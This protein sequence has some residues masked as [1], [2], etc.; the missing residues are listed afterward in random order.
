MYNMTFA[1]VSAKTKYNLE[2]TMDDFI[3]EI[4]KDR[5]E[6]VSLKDIHMNFLLGLNEDFDDDLLLDAILLLDR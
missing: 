2:K 6:F 4:V 5:R 3:F 1:E